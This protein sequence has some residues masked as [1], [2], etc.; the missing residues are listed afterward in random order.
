MR[1]WLNGMRRGLGRLLSYRL[2]T[3]DPE[4]F[5][6][7]RSRLAEIPGSGVL[8]GTDPAGITVTLALRTNTRNKDQAA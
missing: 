6:A 7:A 8:T 3:T 2:E 5:A 4:T 1:A